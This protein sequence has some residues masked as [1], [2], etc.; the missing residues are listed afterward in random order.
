MGLANEVFDYLL[1]CAELI[2]NSVEGHSAQRIKYEHLKTIIP[3]QK[4]LEN[5]HL[6][7]K[8]LF[9]CS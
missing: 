7:Q 2:A 3:P 6:S 9:H 8:R 1:G 5:G 4:R